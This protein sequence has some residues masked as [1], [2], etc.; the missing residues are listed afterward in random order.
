MRT[1]V[2]TRL[3]ASYLVLLIL[4]IAVGGIGILSDRRV[5][6][7]Y[8]ELVHSNLP[9]TILLHKLRE[10]LLEKGM[11]ARGSVL[12]QDNKLVDQS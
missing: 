2:Q 4:M 7:E 5:E 9:I 8:V 3:L 1:G 12:Y 11:A 10:G 6:S